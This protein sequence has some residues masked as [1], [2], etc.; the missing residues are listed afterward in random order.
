MYEVRGIF[1][2]AHDDIPGQ[3]DINVAAGLAVRL[4]ALKVV[5]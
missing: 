2:H 1:R 4:H 3:G 5:D